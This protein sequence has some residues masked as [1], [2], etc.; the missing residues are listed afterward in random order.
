MKNGK[1]LEQ[2][3]DFVEKAVE[4]TKKNTEKAVNIYQK[5]RNDL[6]NDNKSINFSLQQP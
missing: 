6:N 1:N 4:R 3:G 5:R 2:L